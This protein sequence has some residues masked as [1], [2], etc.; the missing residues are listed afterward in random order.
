M[1]EEIYQKLV[2]KY[3]MVEQHKGPV[4]STGSVLLDRAL[5]VGGY[6]AGRI[7]EIYG[8]EG[9]GKTTMG[10]HA[11]AEAQAKKLQAAILD[12]ECSF[13]E[14]YAKAIGVR[15]K[16]NVDYLHLVPTH[17]EEA[18]DLIADLIDQDVKLILIDSVA[19]MVPKAEYEGETGEAF[20]GLQ[21]RMMGQGMRKLTGRISRA[22]A[23]VIFINQVR[24]KIGVFFGSNEVTTGGRALGFYASIRI[25]LR[26]G[27][28]FSDADDPLGRYMKVK[29]VKNK[30]GPP[31]R[32]CQIPIRY[33]VGVDRAWELFGE[34]YRLGWI[35]KQ[36]SFYY[37]GKEKIG[38]GIAKT[39]EAIRGDLK[40]WEKLYH[41]HQKATGA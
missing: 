36:S 39:V 21:A 5:S 23:I 9:V 25:Q 34:F 17:G 40:T 8:P 13:D 38:H 12:M 28:A 16:R 29:I 32:E 20:M 27:D 14:K 6:P 10:L 31:L 3:S 35:K 4:V 22:G 7:I 18:L 30:V 26:N 19:S 1:I 2:D 33:G 41:E 15:G 37:H 11:M 24:S